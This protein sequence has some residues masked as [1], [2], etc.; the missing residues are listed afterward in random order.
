MIDTCLYSP[1]PEFAAFGGGAGAGTPVT[2]TQAEREIAPAQAAVATGT[3]VRIALAHDW[4]VGYRGGE[5]VLEHIARVVHR[6]YEVAGLYTMF[7][8]R[9]A[10]AAQFPAAPPPD[11][12]VR[13]IATLHTSF[14]NRLPG[15][16]VF[17][18][19][20]LPLYPRAVEDLADQL[21]REH[22]REPIDLLISTSSAAIKGLKPPAGVPHVCYC[23]AP[24][25]YLWSQTDLYAQGSGGGLRALGLQAF[26]GSLRDWDTRTSSNVTAFLAN[27]AHIQREIDRCYRRASLVVHPPVDTRFFTM[28]AGLPRYGFW[29]Y[30]GALEPYKRVDILINAA[31]LAGAKLVIVGGGSQAQHLRS[32]S[33]TPGAANAVIE[34]AGRL[35]NSDLLAIYRM[36]G[37]LLFPQIEDF[38]IVAVEA[39]ACGLPVVAYR[40]G[41]ALDSV[42]DGETGVLF[43]AQTPEAIA[44]AAERALS[45]GDVGLAC[46]ANAERFGIERF[47]R[48]IAR[49]IDD[50]LRAKGAHF[51]E[52]EGP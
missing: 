1:E 24:A 48:E 2:R 11:R 8:D 25:R 7:A 49:V 43:D 42:I 16:K 35:S 44:E 27:S 51:T 29:L 34:F 28:R 5:A 46:R 22:A 15:S 4:L 32:L 21:A 3:R 20:M 31:K 41:G 30:V 12:G 23:H 47:E 6:R 10:I 40:A 52:S 9:D 14:V 13:D 45:L 18:R 19:W 39:Q 50:T 17:R 26:G 33:A 38:G 36:A 37:V